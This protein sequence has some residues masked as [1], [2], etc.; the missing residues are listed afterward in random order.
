MSPGYWDSIVRVAE[1]MQR[2]VVSLTPHPVVG[3]I[4]WGIAHG[5]PEEKVRLQK[6]FISKHF[7][8]RILIPDNI[9]TSEHCW[10]AVFR[11]HQW[12]VGERTGGCWPVWPV[13]NTTV[14]IYEGWNMFQ[15]WP[16]CLV[17]LVTEDLL[18][19]CWQFVDPK[20]TM[21]VEVVNINQKGFQPVWL[22]VLCT[23]LTHIS[24][25]LL[26][27][28]ACWIYLGSLSST[29]INIVDA[30][31]EEKETFYL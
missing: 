16:Q 4:L 29:F 31:R 20:L 2:A 5:A 21:K 14:Y 12:R 6:G 30:R 22:E 9:S 7:I 28:P 24:M 13:R 18:S 11:P 25:I 15:T 19:A 27:T 3:H 1:L 10:A 17:L 26:W 23:W 8:S